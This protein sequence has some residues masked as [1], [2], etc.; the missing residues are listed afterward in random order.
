MRLRVHELGGTTGAP[1]LVL[2]PS[3][4]TSVGQLW[5]PVVPLVRTHFR[6]MGWDLPGHGGAPDSGDP[7]G[8][9]DVAR[10]L[11]REIG[12]PFHYAGDSVGGAVGLHLLLE[13]PELVRSA[14]LIATGAKILTAEAWEDRASVVR[15]DGLEVMVD[16][17]RERWFA[18]GNREA[19]EPL[20]GTLR[21]VGVAGYAATCGA[22]AT[23]DVRARL[24]EIRQPVLAVAGAEDVPTP[25]AALKEI[26]AG[27]TDGE[28]VEIPGVAHLPPWEAPDAVADL[29]VGWSVIQARR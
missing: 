10:A 14:V 3:L 24:A 1:V 12:E 2:G 17:S 8:C 23:H 5:G 22:L 9:D 26:A 29:L 25:P 18:P 27:V 6:V 28:F 15:R 11:A 16:G 4:G 21:E 19:G 13:A 7:F 20:L